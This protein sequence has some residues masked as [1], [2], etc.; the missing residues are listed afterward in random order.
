MSGVYTAREKERVLGR[1]GFA[2]TELW[3]VV[4]EGAHQCSIELASTPSRPRA[5]LQTAYPFDFE[6][7]LQTRVSNPDTLYQCLQAIN[8]SREQAPVNLGS[9]LYFPF[10]AGMQVVG[11]RGLRFLDTT[12][13][14][15]T[16]TRVWRSDFLFSAKPRDYHFLDLQGRQQFSLVYPDG[17]G[18][19]LTFGDMIHHAVLWTERAQGN[20]LCFEPVL[21]ANDSFGAPQ[22]IWLRFKQKTHLNYQL[23]RFLEWSR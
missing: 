17:R 16:R 14:P 19:N 10:Q 8:L 22:G 20:F 12:A 11:L 3:E 15:K 21:E 5:H 9:H 18:I 23:R 7:T 1:H 6:L 4:E 13:F 2:R